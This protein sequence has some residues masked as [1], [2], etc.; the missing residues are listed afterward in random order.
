MIIII[1]IIITVASLE[2]KGKRRRR[3][4]VPVERSSATFHSDWNDDVSNGPDFNTFD[5]F[6]ELSEEDKKYFS[7]D[8]NSHDDGDNDDVNDETTMSVFL[9]QLERLKP[10]DFRLSI[11][12]KLSGFNKD[13]NFFAKS[14]RKT[15]NRF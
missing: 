12:L 3:V 11:S 13:G 9:N 4:V 2:T 6:L 7:R 14:R 1:I 10:I 8:F 5:G 15:S